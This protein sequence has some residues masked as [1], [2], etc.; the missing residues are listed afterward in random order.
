MFPAD[1]AA[2]GI[3]AGPAGIGVSHQAPSGLSPHGGA[4]RNMQPKP[5]SARY[6]VALQPAKQVQGPQLR[7][8]CAWIPMGGG[9]NVVENAGLDADPQFVSTGVR[10]GIVAA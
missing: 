5:Y 4:H 2:L 10:C 1:K 8:A 9:S 7:P 6:G 3:Q